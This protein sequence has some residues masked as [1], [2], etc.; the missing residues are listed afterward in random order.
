MYIQYTYMLALTMEK[1]ATNLKKSREVYVE[2]FG[3]MK[4]RE[5]CN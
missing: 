1:D 5:K 2:K 4:G 3:G